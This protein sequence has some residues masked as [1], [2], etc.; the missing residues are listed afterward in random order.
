ML[1]ESAFHTEYVNVLNGTR[2]LSLTLKKVPERPK[3]NVFDIT[4]K[5]RVNLEEATT[6]VIANKTRSTDIFYKTAA[7]RT[8]TI[9]I[10]CC[11]KFRYIFS[12]FQAC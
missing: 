2:Y 5:F 1:Y 11:G 7:V 9:F 6:K 8:R 3:H 10:Y 12:N 4:S